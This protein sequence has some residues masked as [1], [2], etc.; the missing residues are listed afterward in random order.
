MIRSEAQLR[1]ARRWDEESTCRDLKS[2]MSQNLRLM[3]KSLERKMMMFST[4]TQ[5]RKNGDDIRMTLADMQKQM[6]ALESEMVMMEKRVRMFGDEKTKTILD[7]M[8]EYARD[9]SGRPEPIV[10]PVR[11]RP[12]QDT[13]P[14]PTPGTVVNVGQSGK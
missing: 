13:R 6:K 14:K 8:R 4:Y 10:R 5:S 1:N 3:E 2:S 11:T 12:V 9:D 7:A